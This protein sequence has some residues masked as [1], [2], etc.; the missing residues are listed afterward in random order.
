MGLINEK[1]VDYEGSECRAY[2]FTCY[3]ASTSTVTQITNRATGVTLNSTAGQITT[4]D[5]SLAAAAEATFVVTNSYVTAKTVPIVV[6]ASGQTADTSTA[7]VSAVAA[8]S[9]SI[10]VYNHHASTADTGAMVINF[11]LVD[12]N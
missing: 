9:F 1:A 2:L 7:V 12:V 10:T 5:T 6:A 11:V 3:P 8:G 4:D